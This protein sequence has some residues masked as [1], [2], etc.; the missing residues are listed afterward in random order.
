MQRLEQ[1]VATY[2]WFHA[3]GNR[4]QK[5]PL[6]TF[7]TNPEHPDVWDANHLSSVR[8]GTCAEIEQVLAQS[9]RVFEH[10]QHRMVTVDPLTPEPF[11]ARLA[12]DDF[13]ELSPTIH[14]VLE[15]DLH[16][17]AARADLRPITSER[18]WAALYAL[19]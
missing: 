9:E 15:D 3:Y 17:S 12:L 16:Q 18:D 10:C 8:A 6:A 2:A 7:V 14:M 19:T 13:T 1:V 5:D 11:I 4:V